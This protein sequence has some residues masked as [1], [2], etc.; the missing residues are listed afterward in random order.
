MKRRLL[1]EMRQNEIRVYG[2]M[3]NARSSA[4]ARAVQWA[5]E[6]YPESHMVG[7]DEASESEGSVA[8]NGDVEA[9]V[10]RL[11]LDQILCG[12]IAV[13]VVERLRRFPLPGR[14]I[15]PALCI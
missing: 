1:E 2:N 13:Q 3:R 14:L 6:T 8:S 5:R 4:R 11:S 15:R 10:P 12:R 7:V 9:S